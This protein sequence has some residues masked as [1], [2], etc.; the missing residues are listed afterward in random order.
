[1]PII[2]D[3]LQRG[4]TGTAQFAAFK[5]SDGKLSYVTVGDLSLRDSI[6]EWARLPFMR[7]HVIS[8]NQDYRLGSDTTIAGQ[9]WS[10]VDVL[11]GSSVQLRTEKNQPDGYVGL[12]SNG[13]IDPQYIQNIYSN[14]S[15]VVTTLTARNN[16]TTK[17][18]DLAVVNSG[19]SDEGVYVKLN[20]NPAPTGNDDWAIIQNPAVVTSVNGQSGVVSITIA[21]LLQNAQNLT[22]FQDAVGSSQA[23]AGNS[24]AISTLS[25][26]VD[27][28]ETLIGNLALDAKIADWDNTVTYNDFRV[29]MYDDGSGIK[30]YRVKEGQGPVPAGTLPTDTAYYEVISGVAVINY[31]NNSQMEAATATN[32]SVNP[33]QWMYGFTFH[34]ANKVFPALGAQ[35][36]IDAILTIESDLDQAELDILALESGKEDALG[37]PT[38]DDYI[39]SSKADGTRSWVENTSSGNLREVTSGTQAESS[40]LDFSAHLILTMTLTG[41]LDITSITGIGNESGGGVGWLQ[42]TH[43]GHNLTF[44]SSLVDAENVKTFEDTNGVYYITIQNRGTT[45]A[46]DYLIYDPLYVP[47][48]ESSGDGLTPLNLILTSGDL[49]NAS[50]INYTTG[51]QVWAAPASGKIRHFIGGAFKVNITTPFDSGTLCIGY[52]ANNKLFEYPLSDLTSGF[53]PVLGDVFDSELKWWVE[54]TPPTTGDGSL[55]LYSKYTADYDEV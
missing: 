4:A 8:E 6:P 15:Y 10:S 5:E 30:M 21:S 1:M 41:D 39:L 23:V 31:A 45:S 36:V 27:D 13:K 24:G 40:N 49:I 22:D 19:D 9:V 52:D 43:N 25:G 54:G 12:N 26:R 3:T 20:N 7:C 28:I 55:V 2:V 53:W 48:V 42:V 33:L 32:V 47:T 18:G 37:N 50:E 11:S 14:A 51:G 17:T 46:P 34:L 16:L 38:V 35:S 29:V 44:N